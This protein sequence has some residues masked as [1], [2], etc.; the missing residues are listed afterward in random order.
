[1]CGRS[2]GKI[3]HR[4]QNCQKK[5]HH[6]C[7]LVCNSCEDF[8][9]RHANHTKVKQFCHSE[10]DCVGQTLCQEHRYRRCVAVGMAPPQVSAST[11]ASRESERRYW[12]GL[13]EQRR[14]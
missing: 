8:F 14:H 10:G 12:V 3:G 7:K 2:K 11:P 13:R 4:L 6:D 9:R 5:Q 1:V